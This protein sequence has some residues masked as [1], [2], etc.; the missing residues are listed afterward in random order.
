MASCPPCAFLSAAAREFI[1]QSTAA[2][3]E[4]ADL[5]PE[6]VKALRLENSSI[7]APGCRDVQRELGT[8]VE[9]GFTGG[10]SVQ[11]VTPR[12]V[13]GPEIV[14][15]V[16]GGG[17]VCGSPEDD[18]SI[19]ARLAHFL[20]RRVC[21]PRYR[22]A[23]EHPFPAARDDV[24]AVYRALSVEASG[25]LVVG[26][27][28]GGNLALGL[29]LD[30]L[31]TDLLKPVAVALFSPWIDLT[32]SGDSHTTLKGADPTL[33]EEH[34]LKPAGLVYA[35]D[36]PLVSPAI[37]PLFAELPAHGM[38][39]P[40]AISTGTR[41]LLLS[42]S[43]RLA[44]KLRA[45]GASVDLQVAEGLWHVFEWQPQLPESLKSIQEIAAFLGRHLSG[46]TGQN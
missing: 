32:H 2:T 13:G 9:D 40:T 6:G 8:Q 42:D 35:G 36:H 27:S 15:Y 31:A 23:P 17:F 28:A 18:L 5:S 24:M 11:W 4:T 25:L 38:F 46:T 29:V 22:L 37:S 39:P 45:C 41:D 44:A 14:L 19:S 34:F 43:V 30:V 33:D 3:W 21:A 7:A 10:V 1:S 26:E 16:F 12:V 20:G